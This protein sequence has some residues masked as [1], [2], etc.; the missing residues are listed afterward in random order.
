M[1]EAWTATATIIIRLAGSVSAR[2]STRAPSSRAAGHPRRTM[3]WD[4]IGHLL[5]GRTPTTRQHRRSSGIA[6]MASIRAQWRLWGRLADEDPRQAALHHPCLRPGRISMTHMGVWRRSRSQPLRTD[7]SLMM[8]NR[9]FRRHRHLR[10]SCPLCRLSQSRP[11]S[12]SAVLRRPRWPS[13]R[14]A[15]RRP[16]HLSPT[17]S[18]LQHC[19]SAGLLPRQCTTM[20]RSRRNR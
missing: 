7:H 8:T 20:N 2:S 18:R 1:R 15:H 6:A 17:R 12:T 10:P 13:P 4:S 19:A 9:S 14:P 3:P 5:S 11:R 16:R